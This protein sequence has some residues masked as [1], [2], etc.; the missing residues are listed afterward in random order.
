MYYGNK[1][2]NYVIIYLCK[3]KSSYS[4]KINTYIH[5]IIKYNIFL[6]EKYQVFLKIRINFLLCINTLGKLKLPPLV[7]KMK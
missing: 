4:T 6:L 2:R 7:K 5:Q 3:N 1:T